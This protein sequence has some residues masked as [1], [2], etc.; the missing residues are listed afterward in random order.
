[1]PGREVIDWQ[2]DTTGVARDLCREVC[3]LSTDL[4]AGRR[5]LCKDRRRAR[6]AFPA[7]DGHIGRRPTVPWATAPELSAR[8]IRSACSSLASLPASAR[9]LGG[10]ALP[11]E[12]HASPTAPAEQAACVT[13]IVPAH[14]D[15]H[16]TCVGGER[17][18]LWRQIVPW[19]QNMCRRCAAARRV[20][21]TKAKALCQGLTHSCSYCAHI[22]PEC[23]HAAVRC[24][25]RRQRNSPWRHRLP[26]FG[27]LGPLT[28][29]R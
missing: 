21:Q 23:P 1:M 13:Q 14:G 16:K 5:V 17:I 2:Q 19:P 9:T 4:S 25:P 27:K 20:G 10:Q 6:R 28:R 8:W 7:R 26:P 18:D 3:E 24:L 11:P 22:A 12:R 29:R 15:R